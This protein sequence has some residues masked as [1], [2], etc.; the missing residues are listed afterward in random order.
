MKNSIKAMISVV[1]LIVGIILILS[2]LTKPCQADPFKII[3]KM[4]GEKEIADNLPSGSVDIQL[5]SAINRLL[6]IITEPLSLIFLIIGISFTAGGA[7]GLVTNLT[8]EKVSK[9]D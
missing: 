6:C 4:S 1:F 3:G 7:K 8:I 5:P 2:A 9:K